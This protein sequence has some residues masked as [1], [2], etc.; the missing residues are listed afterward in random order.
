MTKTKDVIKRIRIDFR[1]E[2]PIIDACHPLCERH[3]TSI[4][5]VLNDGVKR[6]LSVGSLPEIPAR[7]PAMPVEGRTVVRMTS[8]LRDQFKILCKKQ[9]TTM[10]RTFVHILEEFVAENTVAP[11]LV[12]VIQ[13]PAPEVQISSMLDGLSRA[14]WDA[15]KAAARIVKSTPE[16]F[17]IAAANEKARECLDTTESGRMSADIRIAVA[18]GKIMQ[19]NATTKDWFDR[20]EITQGVLAA[21]PDEHEYGTGANRPAI[22]TYLYAHADEIVRHHAEFE[23]T[24]DHNRRA[25]NARRTAA[26][27][28]VA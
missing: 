28:L 2:A 14:E 11:K 3:D 12:E 22:K 16:S 18:V 20:I 23:I 4:N 9:N 13:K 8:G 19:H 6:Y 24:K 25:S 10:S 1:V 5:E 27:A 17:I 7:D 26:K 15:I 21:K